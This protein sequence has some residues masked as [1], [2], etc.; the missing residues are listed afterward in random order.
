MVMVVIN[1]ELR[2]QIRKE[3]KMNKVQKMKGDMSKELFGMTK[4]EA[5]S[6]GIC[7]NCKEKAFPKCYTIDGW[8][9]YCISGMC[10]QCFDEIC[11]E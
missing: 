7:V 11:G 10:E 5:V 4:D 3:G 9:E 2:L 6:Q 1:G 8:S